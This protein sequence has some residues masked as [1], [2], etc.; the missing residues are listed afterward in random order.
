MPRGVLLLEHED[1]SRDKL[2]E[3]E[4]TARSLVRSRS[5]SALAYLTYFSSFIFL[6]TQASAQ[7]RSEWA[8]SRLA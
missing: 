1:H 8:A 7:N 5:F 6:I 3:I 4:S 2:R